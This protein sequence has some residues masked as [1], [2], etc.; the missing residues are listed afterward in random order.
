VPCGPGW[1]LVGDAGLVM[2]P[3]TG[4]GIADAFRDAELLADAVST[5]FHRG[6]DRALARYQR[7]RDR[8]ARP[9][10]RFTLQLAAL[11]PVGP[12][13]RLLFPALARDPADVQRFLGVLT[14]ALPQSAIFSA[15]KLIR[16]LGTRGFLQLARSPRPK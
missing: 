4:Q 5:G 12:A 13:E 3:I 11:A 6:L 10:Y 16:L 9:T 14:G 2:D 15:P 8:A 7:R 1:A